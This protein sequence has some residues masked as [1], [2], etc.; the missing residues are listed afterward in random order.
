[1]G[2]GGREGSAARDCNMYRRDGMGSLALTEF[3]LINC[4]LPGLGTCKQ[5]LRCLELPS[6][7]DV[8]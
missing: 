7:T 3:K 5:H 2:G 4:K 1:M 8:I 6:G